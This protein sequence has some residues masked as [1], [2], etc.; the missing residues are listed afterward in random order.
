MLL[1]FNQLSADRFHD[2][3]HGII[4][5]KFLARA[6]QMAVDRITARSRGSH[7]RAAPRGACYDGAATNLA[8]A[9][10]IAAALLSSRL[11][12]RCG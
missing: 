12:N 9:S 4:D 10:L 8:T 7:R 1:N 5:A 2:R 11:A 6:F 3:E